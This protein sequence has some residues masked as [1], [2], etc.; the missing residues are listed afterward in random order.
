MTGGARYGLYGRS[1][2]HSPM[3]I[4]IVLVTIESTIERG[5]KASHCYFVVNPVVSMVIHLS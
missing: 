1:Y 4:P 5:Q 3:A 2:Y